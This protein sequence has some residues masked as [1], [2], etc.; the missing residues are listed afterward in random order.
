MATGGEAGSVYAATEVTAYQGGMV[1]VEGEE[2][3][4][5]YTAQEY[6]LRKFRVFLSDGRTLMNNRD[7]LCDRGSRLL[8]NSFGNTRSGRGLRA[9]VSFIR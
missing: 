3:V 5:L 8:H 4:R 9:M 2:A 7:L 1:V 6:L